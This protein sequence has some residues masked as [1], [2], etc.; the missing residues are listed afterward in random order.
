MFLFLGPNSLDFQL[1]LWPWQLYLLTNGPIGQKSTDS[2]LNEGAEGN[3]GQWEDYGAGTRGRVPDVT[4]S[5]VASTLDFSDPT[6]KQGSCHFPVHS[7]K[8]PS[9][10]CILGPCPQPGHDWEGTVVTLSLKILCVLALVDGS[11]V[12]HSLG[13]CLAPQPAETSQSCPQKYTVLQ[14]PLVS[15]VVPSA[16]NVQPSNAVPLAL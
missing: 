16:R 9:K 5:Q 13:A 4:P 8:R 3:F 1:L 11:S 10:F 15:P 14:R 6:I 7:W 12:E 2:W